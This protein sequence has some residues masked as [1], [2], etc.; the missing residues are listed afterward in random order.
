MRADFVE[1]GRRADPERQRALQLRV[2]ALLESHG[3]TA[4][5]EWGASLAN[6]K[7]DGA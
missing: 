6:A 2:E 3:A 4:H 7:A 1:I 5:R